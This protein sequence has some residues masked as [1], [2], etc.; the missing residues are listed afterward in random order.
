MSQAT[1]KSVLT[2]DPRR[3][4]VLRRIVR[5]ANWKRGFFEGVRLRHFWRCTRI[6]P[7]I[8]ANHTREQSSD[9]HKPQSSTQGYNFQL[10][11]RAK[12]RNRRLHAH[13]ELM[14]VIAPGRINKRSEHKNYTVGDCL[15]CECSNWLCNLVLMTERTKIKRRAIYHV[16]LLGSTQMWH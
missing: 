2:V 6:A 15:C 8:N 1:H 10:A 13:R 4:I 11:A 7:P 14:I 12:N 3:R 9:L 5:D 16:F